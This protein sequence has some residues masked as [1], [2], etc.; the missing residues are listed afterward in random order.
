MESFEVGN[1][2]TKKKL[3]TTFKQILQTKSS[4]QN[5]PMDSKH[6]H[7]Q[8][9]QSITN[10]HLYCLAVARSPVTLQSDGLETQSM[11]FKKS[12]A[13]HSPAQHIHHESG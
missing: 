7:S 8:S 4:H 13:Q 10:K 1:Y 5:I 9:V 2:A 12:T 11:E 6:L 3:Q